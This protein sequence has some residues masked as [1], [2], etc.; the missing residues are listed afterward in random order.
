MYIIQT[1]G[2]I[3]PQQTKRQCSIT[4]DVFEIIRDWGFLLTDE[5]R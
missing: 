3:D 5:I 1:E 2:V 4:T